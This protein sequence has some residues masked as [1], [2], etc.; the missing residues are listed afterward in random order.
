MVADW[1]QCHFYWVDRCIDSG[2]RVCMSPHRHVYSTHTHKQPNRLQDGNLV[3]WQCFAN[4]ASKRN[5]PL[6]KLRGFHTY[7][8]KLKVLLLE[9]HKHTYDMWVQYAHIRT[10]MYLYLSRHSGTYDSGLSEQEQSQII[11]P[12]RTVLS[13]KWCTYVPRVQSCRITL[14]VD[15]TKEEG[16]DAPTARCK[17]LHHTPGS[18]CIICACHQQL[19]TYVRMREA[20]VL[21]VQKYICTYV[22][23]P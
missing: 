14:S 22:L 12:T 2:K 6:W 20:R 1:Y 4:W 5:V 8:C 9:R 23:P 15:K 3:K 16:L 10:Y 18:S 19:R 7:S 13:P 17:P 11:V 21:E